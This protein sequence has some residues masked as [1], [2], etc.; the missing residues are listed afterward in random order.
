MLIGWHFLYEGLVKVVNPYWTAAD[1]LASA[2]GPASGLF[3][4]LVADPSRLAVV[5]A[6][7]RW[8]L[9][10]I[11]AA[12]IAGLLT[13][14][15]AAAGMVL[16]FLYYVGNPPLPAG[17]AVLPAEGSYLVVDKVLVELA[18]L[19]VVFALPT[20]AVVGLDRLFA[21]TPAGEAPGQDEAR[22]AA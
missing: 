6:L 15:A 1:Y 18:A 20:G 9:V 3:H 4:W 10:V 2:R 8:G 7:N 11:G 22:R 17:T 12:L 21:R 14:W 16:L 5:D 13:R 19:W